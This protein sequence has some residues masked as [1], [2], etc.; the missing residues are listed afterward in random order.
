MKGLYQSDDRNHT[1]WV[2]GASL[3]LPDG[4][5]VPVEGPPDWIYS[6]HSD[7]DSAIYQARFRVEDISEIE[8]TADGPW[9]CSVLA[10]GPRIAFTGVAHHIQPGEPCRPGDIAVVASAST[11]YT[12]AVMTASAVICGTGGPLAHLP[13]VGREV[14]K[15]VVR[16]T[17]ALTRI[18]DGERI[19]IDVPNNEVRKS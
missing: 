13:V 3:V 11:D 14:G 6:V 15:I 17:D 9:T 12:K 5:V 19:T 10:M 18:A 2:L 1:D 16:L 8:D 4:S 7:I